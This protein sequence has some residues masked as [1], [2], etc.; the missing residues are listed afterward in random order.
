MKDESDSDLSEEINDQ[1]SQLWDNARDKRKHLLS[2]LTPYSKRNQQSFNSSLPP[3][4]TSLKQDIREK[5]GLEQEVLKL[6]E[7]LEDSVS[8]GKHRDIEMDR[9]RKAA[10]QLAVE[11]KYL[12][13]ELQQT[14]LPD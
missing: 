13:R 12:V 9:L 10:D 6:R 2:H 14:H 4:D 8:H 3:P 11:K 7:Q 1:L 5:S